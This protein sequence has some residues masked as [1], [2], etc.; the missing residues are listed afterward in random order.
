MMVTRLFKDRRI[1]LLSLLLLLVVLVT[2]VALTADQAFNAVAFGGYWFMLALAILAGR[3][4]ARTGVGGWLRRRVDRRDWL[5]VVILALCTTVWWAHEKPGFKILADEVLLLGTSMGMHY[6]RAA[7]YPSRATDVQGPFQIL[8]RVLDKRPLLF[9]FLV[10]TV[11]DLTGYRPNNAFYFNRGVG[12][13]FLAL[14]YV[15]GWQLTERRWA[16]IFA[17]LVFAGLPLA[18][19][20]TAGSGFELLNLTMLTALALALLAYLRSPD[21]RKLEALVY[22]GLAVSACRYES[23]VFL[24]PVALAALVGWSRQN[25]VHLTWLTILSPVLLAPWL[26]QNRLFSGASSAWQM[27][28]KTGVQSPFGL[29]YLAPNMGHALAFFFDFTGFQASSAFFAVIGLLALPFFLLWA[30]GVVRKPRPWAGS[31]LAVVLFSA[32]L[33]IVTGVLL[34]YFWG[35]FDDR[36][37]SRLS[38]PVHLLMLIAAVVVGRL[39]IKSDQGWKVAAGV[40]AVAAM[41]Q[42][43]PVMA[44][45][46]YEIDYP[47]G[48]EMELRR[49]FLA[50]HPEG[51]F[52]FIDHDSVFWIT[53]LVPASSIEAAQ[54]RREGL[55]Y[56]LRNHSFTGI[57]VFQS[58]LVDG[59]TG[60]QRVDPEDDLGPGFVLQQVWQR[61]VQTLLFARISRVVAIENEGVTTRETQEVEPLPDKMSEDEIDKMRARYLENWIKQLP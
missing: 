20:Q 54:E 33:A 23:V 12:V 57:Y 7:I 53:Q 17:V 49:D 51:G 28:S 39:M 46:A 50:A 30:I 37:I 5:V 31:D 1:W 24:L 47:P 27:G 8:D 44:Q 3:A 21:A 43:L 14:I 41:A 60:E 32:G 36:I 42:G 11:H 55:A 61:K 35:Q 6:E 40:A 38:L 9:P 25:D 13:V 56:H 19:Q 48:L 58:V 10:A 15:L 34:L 2:R 29:E 22:L 52:L 26:M 16:G 18:A 59:D 45:R 4:V